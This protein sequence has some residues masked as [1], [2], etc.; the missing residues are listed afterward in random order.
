MTVAPAAAARDAATFQVAPSVAAFDRGEWD[1]VATVTTLRWD[2]LHALEAIGIG[3]LER[4]YLVARDET[5]AIVGHT[6]FFALTLPLDMGVARAHPLARCARLVRRLVPR[7]FSA[8]VVCCGSALTLGHALSFAPGTGAALRAAFMRALLGEMEA[9]ARR[10]GARTLL[11]REFHDD[12]LPLADAAR[13]A[14]YMAVP[15]LDDTVLEIRWPTFDAYLRALKAHYRHMIEKQ[16]A[17]REGAGVRAEHVTGWTAHAETMAR[18]FDGTASR[19]TALPL[20]GADYFRALS[21]VEGQRA[22]L[23]REGDALVGFVLY[24]VDDDAVVSSS[25]G[26]DYACND[27]AALV[28]NAYLEVVRAAIELGRPRIW[29][30]RTSYPSK[31]RLGA[32]AVP[33]TMFIR[34]RSPWLTRLAGRAARRFIQPPSPRRWRVFKREALP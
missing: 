20:P 26:V 24:F 10:T 2:Y 30:G 19:H 21:G 32:E 28:F 11:L 8:R 34:L 23:F 1:A 4:R 22:V 33:L 27:R 13:E 9:F 17:A 18:L 16:T 12:E 3:D 29:F 6:Y 5:G 25:L 7:A 31:Y 15:N 14:G